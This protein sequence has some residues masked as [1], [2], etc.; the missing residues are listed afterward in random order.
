VADFVLAPFDPVVDVDA[1]VRRSA[2]AVESIA[3][4]GLEAAQQRF[5]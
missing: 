5:N 1:L 4:D 2:D 3:R